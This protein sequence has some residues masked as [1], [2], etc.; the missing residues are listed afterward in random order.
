MVEKNVLR[1]NDARLGWVLS[2]L[3]KP[4]TSATAVMLIDNGN[5]I[6]LRMPWHTTLDNTIT[7][8]KRWWSSMLSLDAGEELKTNNF[9]SEILFQDEKGMVLLIGCL[10]SGY[11]SKG[12]VGVGRVEARAVVIDAHEL[13]YTK[14]NGMRTIMPGLEKW[15]SISSVE[16]T[17]KKNDEGKPGSFSINGSSG[18]EILLSEHMG[19]ALHPRWSVESKSTGEQYVTQFVELETRSDGAISWEDHLEK[20]GEFRDLVRLAIWAPV[21]YQTVKVNRESDPKTLGGTSISERWA[22]LNSYLIVGYDGKRGDYRKPP[23]T[24][25][26]IKQDGYGKWREICKNFSRGVNPLMALLNDQGSTIEML[27]TQ[28]VIGLE[29][30]ALQTAIEQGFAKKKR[31]DESIALRLGRLK[32]EVPL[33]FLPKDWER[34]CAATYNGIK[35]ANR[36]MPKFDTVHENYL[37]CVLLFRLWVANR[38]GV[39]P[40]VLRERAERDP[41]MRQLD[42][43]KAANPPS[44]WYSQ[45]EDK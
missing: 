6:E 3:P 40:A 5:K 26:D 22:K 10:F 16:T 43:L 18:E 42:H 4:L 15:L 39:P 44:Q 36:T 24:F 33:D 27:L 14:V 28:S 23:F 21:G 41:I 32:K 45:N 30:L 25:E 34:K 9:P 13:G 31:E 38:I 12:Q 2:D 35:H 11:E 7:S 1:Q 19:L 29:A 20:H 37:Q 17:I 8:V